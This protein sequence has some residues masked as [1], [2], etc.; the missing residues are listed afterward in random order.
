MNREIY[1]TDG[2]YTLL[3]I[4]DEDRENYI[5]LHRQ[6]NG[7]QTLFLNP[8]CKDRKIEW[9]V[10]HFNI[11]IAK[12]TIKCAFTLFFVEKILKKC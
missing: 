10:K 4:S 12:S 2:E 1:A 9:R 5:E 3:P 11:Y 8:Y 6:L 7:K